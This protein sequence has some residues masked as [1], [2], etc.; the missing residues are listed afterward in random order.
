MSS[1]IADIKNALQS[2]LA[3]VEGVNRAYA[4]APAS[5]PPGDLP[6]A[7]PFTG[8]AQYS[9]SGYQTNPSPD[10]TFTINLYGKQVGQGIDGEAERLL[11]PFL[12]RIPAALAANPRLGLEN[13]WLATLQRDS[14]VVVLTFAEEKYIGVA[15]TVLVEDIR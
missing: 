13:V 1:E 5:L 9:R 11:E 6:A 3:A 8:Q 2:I 4:Y 12:E 14:G 15:F 10:R 7:I